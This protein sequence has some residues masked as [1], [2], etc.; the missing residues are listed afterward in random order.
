MISFTEFPSLTSTHPTER[1]ISGW[2][3]LVAEM[4]QGP[5][6]TETKESVP[7]WCPATFRFPHRSS[8]NVASLA[9]AAFD[10]D[11]LTPEQ[12]PGFLDQLQGRAALV[13]TS[14]SHGTPKKPIAIR[15]VLALT[16]PVPASEWLRVWHGVQTL[17]GF[18]ADRQT[19]DPSRLFFRYSTHPDRRDQAFARVFEGAAL[20]WRSLPVAPPEP[21]KTQTPR[22]PVPG[23]A[24]ELEDAE[25]L[26]AQGI[27]LG[28][29]VMYRAEHPEKFAEQPKG[30]GRNAGVY[31]LGAISK[32]EDLSVDQSKDLLRE[33]LS[34]FDPVPDSE[35]LKR[36]EQTIA[37]AYNYSKTGQGEVK[38][39]REIADEF[40]ALQRAKKAKPANDDQEAES[41]PDSELASAFIERTPPSVSMLL[42]PFLQVAS[43]NLLAAPGGSA[44]TWAALDWAVAIAARG[45]DV[46]YVAQEDPHH[47]VAERVRRLTIGREEARKH[48][49]LRHRQGIKLDDPRWVDRLLQE[50]QTRGYRLVVIDT[51]AK[52]HTGNENQQQDV[53][54]FIDAAD[55]IVA[56]GA[57]VLFVHHANRAGELRGSTAL[58]D[59]CSLVIELKTVSKGRSGKRLA[60]VMKAKLL[61]DLEGSTYA[62]RVLDKPHDA[63]TVEWEPVQSDDGAEQ[64]G[65]ELEGQVLE[66]L[67]PWTGDLSQGLSKV[68][69][70]DKLGIS[71]SRPP[72]QAALDALKAAGR[73]KY[74]K[75]AHGGWLLFRLDAPEVPFPRKGPK[76]SEIFPKPASLLEAEAGVR[77]G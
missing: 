73:V 12:L 42:E 15:V 64:T 6:V 30:D 46:L 24:E 8:E 43:I 5:I 76:R 51:L 2:P 50:V 11:G 23:S 53:G 31:Q 1:R 60:E 59:G 41:F 77:R 29:I 25:L 32:E 38:R 45:E 57:A 35:E 56:L 55:R 62:L 71:R 9:V 21:L 70:A 40:I 48:L 39:D 19:K 7:L 37:D 18:T 49:R 34:L 52:S 66:A 17:L 16:E 28:R 27:A 36:Y 14:H 54:R 69:I 68:Q 75:N 58:P 10:V 61:P 3:A 63:V 20:D 74:Q 44:K 13:Y 33:N 4:L 65:E 72:L 47:T 22:A 26:K 67:A